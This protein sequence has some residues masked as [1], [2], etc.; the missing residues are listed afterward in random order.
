M[1]KKKRI[2]TGTPSPIHTCTRYF[3]PQFMRTQVCLLD[4]P[5]WIVDAK[6]QKQN[7]KINGG[8]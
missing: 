8:K 3:F 4:N 7:K 6:K 2:Q 1:E 5:L